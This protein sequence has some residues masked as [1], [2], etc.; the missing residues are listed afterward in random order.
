MVGSLQVRLQ[1]AEV[2]EAVAKAEFAVEAESN[3]VVSKHAE[4]SDL[5]QLEA[6]ESCPQKAARLAA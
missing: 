5:E 6:V 2:V 4:A 1:V 3:Y